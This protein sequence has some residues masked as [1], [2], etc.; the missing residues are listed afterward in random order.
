MDNVERIEGLVRDVDET[1][2]ELVRSVLELHGS[3]LNRI[4]EIAAD[5]GP[6]GEAMIRRFARDELVSSILVLHDLHP[7]DI[8]TRVRRALG[9]WPGQVELVGAF[10]GLVRV[11]IAGG[12]CGIKESVETA[13]REAAPDAAEVA[14]EEMARPGSFVPLAALG[15]I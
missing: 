12:A 7:D 8:E 15:G 10:H 13:I 3:A 1:A 6:E 11:R 5:C 4:M 2:Q 9:K 14:I